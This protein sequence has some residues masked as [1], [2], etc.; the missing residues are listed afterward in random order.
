MKSLWE[1]YVL[2]YPVFQKCWGHHCAWAMLQNQHKRSVQGLVHSKGLIAETRIQPGQLMAMNLEL[3][4]QPLSSRKMN[5]QG[6][7]SLWIPLTLLLRDMDSLW[8]EH[9]RDWLL[10]WFRRKYYLLTEGCQTDILIMSIDRSPRCQHSWDLE[11]PQGDT[12]PQSCYINRDNNKDVAGLDQSHTAGNCR[13]AAVHSSC[14]W[15]IW[16]QLCRLRDGLRRSDTWA[17]KYPCS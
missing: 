2:V 3:G 8:D 1:W 17:G 16:P 5:I 15:P 14:C 12:K 13:P 10:H 7:R 9:G 11:A 4:L 6:R